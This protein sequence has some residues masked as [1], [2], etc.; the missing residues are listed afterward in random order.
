MSIHKSA[1]I[2]KS[3]TI[4][5]NVSIEA[6][7]IIGPNVRIGANTRIGPHVLIECNTAVGENSIIHKG[8]AVGVVPQ[9]L[10]FQDQETFL[11]IGNRAVL[12]EYCTI[13]R[14]SDDKTIIGNDFVLM[15]HGHVSQDCRIG[16]GVVLSN[17]V[18]LMAHV[19]IA[20]YVIVGG[21][22][23]INRYCRVGELAF[24]GGGFRAVKDVPPFIVA[25]DEPLQIS[26]INEI[27]LKKRDFS[28]AAIENISQAYMI[29]HVT[30]G[31]PQEGL[32]KIKHE[33][34]QTPEVQRILEFIAGSKKG[35][36]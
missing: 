7:T 6:Y 35:I 21:L 36:I 3:S 33:V 17:S 29:L 27:A 31:N 15:C 1:Q 13:T 28:D 24:I 8:A 25:G 14:G 12:R 22:T 10:K 30:Q 4:G 19:T 11:E 32:E 16:N 26:G 23:F 5:E 34:N 20:D 9:D 2:H 18:I